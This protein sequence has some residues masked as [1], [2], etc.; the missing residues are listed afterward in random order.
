MSLDPRNIVSI[1]N[2]KS[3]PKVG[4]HE[5]MPQG[6][7]QCLSNPRYIQSL[8]ILS[9]LLFF[10]IGIAQGYAIQRPCLKLAQDVS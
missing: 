8:Q 9:N 1:Q 5:D 2:V 7:L 10:K 6:L 3:C 4:Q